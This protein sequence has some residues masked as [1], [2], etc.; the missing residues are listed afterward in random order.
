MEAFD[1]CLSAAA[2]AGKGGLSAAYKFYNRV[3]SSSGLICALELGHH[4]LELPE[5][6]STRSFQTVSL[7]PRARTLRQG[8]DGT[9]LISQTKFEIYMGRKSHEP[10]E[11]LRHPISGKVYSAAAF[12]RKLGRSSYWQFCQLYYSRMHRGTRTTCFVKEVKLL[13]PQPYLS[14][15]SS[16]LARDLRLALRSFLVLGRRQ[17]GI[18]N[19]SLKDIEGASPAKLGEWMQASVEDMPIFV[20]K[21]WEKAPRRNERE[22][23]RAQRND[24]TDRDPAKNPQPHNMSAANSQP[25]A[26]DSDEYVALQKLEKKLSCSKEI[27]LES[28]GPM[29]RVNK[30]WSK[31]RIIYVGYRFAKWLANKRRPTYPTVAQLKASLRKLSP[32]SAGL[33][34][35]LIERFCCHFSPDTEAE[36]MQ[37]L[38]RQ[39]GTKIDSVVQEHISRGANVFEDGMDDCWYEGIEGYVLAE[40]QQIKRANPSRFINTDEGFITSAAGDLKKLYEERAAAQQAS[41]QQ[42]KKREY[43]LDPTQ[44]CLPRLLRMKHSGVLRVILVGL[45]GTGKSDTCK[46]IA[47]SGPPIQ[48]LS[49]IEEALHWLSSTKF[50][51]P[52]GVAADVLRDLNAETL[53]RLLK[54]FR[55]EL[56]DSDL[57]SLADVFEKSR[58]TGTGR[59]QYGWTM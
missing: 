36:T 58:K 2:D 5:L 18:K 27:L 8:N 52:T 12:K 7:D 29:V 23:Q 46:E 11:N 47:V 50:G 30:T 20:R 41:K 56:S 45:A 6:F 59:G 31:L 19:F 17:F 51:A 54:L 10:G 42:H 32:N 13:I 24:R 9:T 33:K 16:N 44:A 35:V 37:V 34:S 55:G 38:R 25:P 3:V 57:D 40:C 4:I 1:A 26:E 43:P 28:L 39:K 21:S 22:E 53:D 48:G 49:P 14:F 15:M